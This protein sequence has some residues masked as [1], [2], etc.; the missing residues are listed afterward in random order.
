[1][2]SRSKDQAFVHAPATI[3]GLPMACVMNRLVT[4]EYSSP[5]DSNGETQHP[6]RIQESVARG[7]EAVVTRSSPY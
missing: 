3:E 6:K 1:M 5:K 2:K 4:L 7:I